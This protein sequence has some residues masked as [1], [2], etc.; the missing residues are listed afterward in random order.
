MKSQ[1][2]H[3]LAPALWIGGGVMFF[4]AAALGKQVAFAGVGAL[5]VLLGVAAMIRARKVDQS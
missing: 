1:D 3:R 5:F 2:L 4:L